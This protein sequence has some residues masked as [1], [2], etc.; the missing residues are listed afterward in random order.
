MS[1]NHETIEIF[2]CGFI[3]IRI[4]KNNYISELKPGK[5]DN[6]YKLQANSVC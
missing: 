2:L 4:N 5:G 6:S 3:V 1:I